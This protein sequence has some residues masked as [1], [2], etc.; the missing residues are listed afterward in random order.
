MYYVVAS[1]LSYGVKIETYFFVNI[2][3][4]ACK[5]YKL[6]NIPSGKILI[7]MK[8]KLSFDLVNTDQMACSNRYVFISM[9]YD[10]YSKHKHRFSKGLRSHVSNNFVIIV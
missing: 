10:L 4:P 5:S 7:Q 2:F 9:N 1:R 8:L 3:C 6:T